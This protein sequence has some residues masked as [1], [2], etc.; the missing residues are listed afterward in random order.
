MMRGV[1]TREWQE[2]VCGS[3]TTERHPSRRLELAEIVC[4]HRKILAA[5]FLPWNAIIATRSAVN[6]RQERSILSVNSTPTYSRSPIR[7]FEGLTGIDN[8]CDVAKKST[9]NTVR[10]QARYHPAINSAAGHRLIIDARSIVYSIDLYRP[11]MSRKYHMQCTVHIKENCTLHTRKS[12]LQ[13]FCQQQKLYFIIV[14][15]LR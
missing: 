9:R 7:N 1:T 10:T 12:N 3:I 4:F 15:D 6:I 2:E 11:A 5:T 14:V 13:M 8:I